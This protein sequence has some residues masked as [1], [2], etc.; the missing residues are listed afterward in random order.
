MIRKEWYQVIQSAREVWGLVGSPIPDQQTE[1]HMARIS[2]QKDERVWVWHFHHHTLAESLRPQGHI[3]PGLIS[4]IIE[5][6]NTDFRRKPW[7][8]Q[9]LRRLLFRPIQGALTLWR[10]A[11]SES[12]LFQLHARECR[13]CPWKGR[14][15]TGG[16]IFTARREG[17]GLWT[18]KDG[19]FSR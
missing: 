5:V 2:V 6:R 7:Y 18:L 8:E 17:D 4:D 10:G 11:I 13:K 15:V 19:T 3:T 1:R 16:T 12:S 9:Q 14:R